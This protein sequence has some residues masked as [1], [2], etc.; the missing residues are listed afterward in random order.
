MEKYLYKY[1]RG[2]WCHGLGIEGVSDYDY[3]GVYCDSINNIIGLPS[4]YITQMSDN[5][6]DEVYYEL[7]RWCELLSKSN[8]NVIEGL[9]V[10]DEFVVGEINPIIQNFINNRELFLTKELMTG[11][12]EFSMAQVKKAVGY[13]KK[14]QIPEDFKRKDIL[15][16]CYTF[17]NQ[18]SMPL[19]Q[20]LGT[21][22]LNQKYCGLVNIPNMPSCY[23]LYYDWWNHFADENISIDDL[24]D[25]YLHDDIMWCLITSH[26]NLNE[27]DFEAT[28]DW[29]KGL[30]PAGYKGIMDDEGKSTSLRLSSVVKHERPICYVNYNQDGYVSH[31]KKYK[32]WS[33]WKEKR[34]QQRYIDNKG[35]NFDA[36]NMCE[37]VRLLHTAI[38]LARDGKFNVKRD[39]DREF[40]LN[41]KH[42]K[43]DYNEIYNYITNKTEELTKYVPESSLP[44]NINIQLINDMLISSRKKYYNII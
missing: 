6:N 2:S 17:H 14:S 39:W 43:M 34:N 8:P 23:G 36:K 41:I 24:E 32:E 1:I 11:M 10:D 35:Y 25:K 4:N 37:T 9:F 29:F 38:E 21:Y 30:K 40:L 44:N 26:Y 12:Y 15:D 13:N 28:E 31:C 7:G 16:F 27:Y 20:W 42:H 3:S 18:G 5:K 22:G 19:K 33:E